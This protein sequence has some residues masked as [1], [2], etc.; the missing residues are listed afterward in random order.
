[1]ILE[2]RIPKG[3]FAVF[4]QVHIPQGLGVNMCL[5]VEGIPG[6]KTAWQ[7]LNMRYSST[8]VIL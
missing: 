1:M 2:V 7:R 5:D 4:S 8:G 3:L 6:E